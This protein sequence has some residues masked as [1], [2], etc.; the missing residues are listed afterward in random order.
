M[1]LILRRESSGEVGEG[2]EVS[3]PSVALDADVGSGKLVAGCDDVELLVGVCEV[4]MA[5][6]EGGQTGVEERA[7][8]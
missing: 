5:K 4:D 2:E 8:G 1:S 7:A 3:P 6:E